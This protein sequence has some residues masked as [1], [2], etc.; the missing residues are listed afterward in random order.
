MPLVEI[1]S[2]LGFANQGTFHR[3]FKRWTGRAPGEFR[4]GLKRL[5]EQ[6]EAHADLQDQAAA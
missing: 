6:D 4:T 2:A 1:A 5:P 3:A